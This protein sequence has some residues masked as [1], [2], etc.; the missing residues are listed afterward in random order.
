MDDAEES[1]ISEDKMSGPDEIRVKT[2]AQRRVD[3]SA[4]CRVVATG[5]IA[6]AWGLLAG[7]SKLRTPLA[8]I[9]VGLVIT[10]AT[11]AVLVFLMDYAQSLFEYLDAALLRGRFLRPG[12]HLMFI[13]KQVLTFSAAAAILAAAVILIFQ[14][15]P[16]AGQSVRWTSLW[17]GTVTYDGSPAERRQSKLY[18]S[19]PDAYTAVITADE[20]GKTC[21]GPLHD[22]TLTLT[23]AS[24]DVHVS[25]HGIIDGEGNGRVYHGTWVLL[26]SERHGSF[27]YH[28]SKS[29]GQ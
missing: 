21:K 16:A 23:C 27:E 1:P 11:L 8:S 3:L 20:N 13:G 22:R 25:L 17:I 2:A 10:A 28:F 29:V 12:G 24:P 15:S 9:T 7:E 26:E 4:R 14:P 19:D 6:V 18:M 5:I